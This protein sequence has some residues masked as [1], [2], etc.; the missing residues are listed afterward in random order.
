[1]VVSL[2]RIIIVKC[3]NKRVSIFNGLD[4]KGLFFIFDI[5]LVIVDRSFCF[6]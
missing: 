4:N 5:F 1:M 6:M 3:C 2:V